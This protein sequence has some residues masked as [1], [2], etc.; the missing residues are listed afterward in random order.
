MAEFKTRFIPYPNEL[1]CMGL[2][3]NGNVNDQGSVTPSN[4]SVTDCI[5]GIIGFLRD[6]LGLTHVPTTGEIDTSNIVYPDLPTMKDKFNDTNLFTRYELGFVKFAFNDELQ[7][8]KPLFLNFKFNFIQISGRNSND[9]WRNRYAFNM[10]LEILNG[11][12]VVMHSADLGNMTGRQA[13][14]TPC[15]YGIQEQ[16]TESHGF[17]AGNRLYVSMLPNRY[18][19][20]VST[21]IDANYW[22][23]RM[24]SYFSFYIER[25]EEFVKFLQLSQLREASATSPLDQYS[26]ANFVY[27]PYDPNK[28]STNENVYIPYIGNTKIGNNLFNAFRT[29]DL[30]PKTNIVSENFNVLSCYSDQIAVSGN[31]VDIEINGEVHKYA[32][33]K[34]ANNINMYF[35]RTQTTGLLFRIT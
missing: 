24:S 29:I 6:N 22:G 25:N 4:E 11:N 18:V 5:I 32:T 33:Y 28:F 14:T 7:D 35:V 2:L 13:W 12:G 16:Q 31:T 34:N 9:W 10:T 30:N 26:N 20:W 23:N 1:E 27:C 19:W 17:Y 3:R 8:T 21:S 15:S